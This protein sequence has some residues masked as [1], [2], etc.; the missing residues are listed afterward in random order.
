MLSLVISAIAFFVFSY[1]LK[2]WADDYELPKGMT[3][4]VSILIVAIALS[5]G[6]AWLVD[7]VAA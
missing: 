2:R 7:K 5:Y 4:S 6:V 1:F 3:R